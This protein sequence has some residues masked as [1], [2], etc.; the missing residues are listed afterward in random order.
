[1][2]VVESKGAARVQPF[3]QNVM[4]RDYGILN[5]I[6]Q[7]GGKMRARCLQRPMEVMNSTEPRPSHRMYWPET[8]E[9]LTFFHRLAEKNEGT[10]NAE[11]N[12]SNEFY[13]ARTFA[14]NLLARDCGIVDISSQA[15]GNE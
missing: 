7:A 13:R 3:A 2:V 9:F 6:P 15:G 8:V 14:Q 4:A 12:G 1:M 5:L 11:T 10:V